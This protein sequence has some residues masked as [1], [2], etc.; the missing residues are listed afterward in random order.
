MMVI[1]DEVLSDPDSYVRE[2]LGGDF[3][4]VQAGDQLFKG[5]QPREVDEFS[6]F[7]RKRFGGVV[8]YNFVRRSPAGQEEPNFIHSDEMMGDITAVLYLNRQHP[9]D[10]GTIL[11]DDDG[12]QVMKAEMKYNRCVVFDSRIKHSRAVFDN[13]GDGDDARL[14]QVVF[15]S[16]NAGA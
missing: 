12:V 15:I 5:I 1:Y 4:D 10:E 9:E 6:E 14:V 2:V 8:A 16:K 3:I 7:I 11:Y 13:F